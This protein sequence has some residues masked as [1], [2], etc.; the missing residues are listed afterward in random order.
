MVVLFLEGGLGNQIFQYAAART[1]SELRNND[2]III[3]TDICKTSKDRKCGLHRFLLPNMHIA[4]ET[5]KKIV[6]YRVAKTII[7]LYRRYGIKD[8]RIS[9]FDRI[10]QLFLNR[11]GIYI[12]VG[13]FEDAPIPASLLKKKNIY[14]YGFFQRNRFIKCIKTID[15]KW[16]SP[17]FEMWKRNVEFGEHVCVHIRL[18]DYVDNS[19]FEVCSKDY[20]YRAMKYIASIVENPVFHIFSDDMAVVKTGF[21]FEYPVIFEEEKNIN[22]C[23]IKMSLCKHFILSNSTFSWWAQRLCQ[24]KNKVV[25]APAQWYSDKNIPFYLYEKDWKKIEV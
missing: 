6:E 13:H 1:L 14:I 12:H 9:F 5:E 25:A 20:Y 17:Q 24:N 3:D 11:L 16:K 7:Q 22:E 19:F 18:G 2:S 21:S 10:F 15:L 4:T 23:L 8:S